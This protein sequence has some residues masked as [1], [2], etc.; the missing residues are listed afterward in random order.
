MNIED[1]Q[2]ARFL[3]HRGDRGVAQPNDLLNGIP[4]TVI[5]TQEVTRLIVHEGGGTRSGGLLYTLAQRIVNIAGGRRSVY[6][7]EEAARGVIGERYTAVS[8]GMARRVIGIGPRQRTRYATELV[9][10][11]CNRECRIRGAAIRGTRLRPPRSR[12]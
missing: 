1:A 12:P 7:G 4:S 3:A 8:R 11:T 2:A 10:G 6:G 9:T 5:L